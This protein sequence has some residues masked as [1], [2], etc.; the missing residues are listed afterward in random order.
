MIPYIG[1]YLLPAT[2]ALQRIALR[3]VAAWFLGILF[4][5]FI[6]LRFDV[7][8]DWSSYL[9]HLERTAGLGVG[10]VLRRDEPGYYL[11]N[12]LAAHL[13]AGIWLVNLVCG[14]L[15]VAGLIR[16]CRRMPEPFLALA[17]ATPYIVTVVAMGYTRQATAFGLVLW[18]LVYLFDQRRLA[19][20]VSV[21]LAAT[22]HKSAV[23]MLPLAVLAATERRVWTAF[24][25]GISG[26][27]MYLL[28]L[29][30]Q[31]AT[32]W[33]NY[34]ESDYAMASEG[35]P[36]RVLMNVVPAAVLLLFHRRFQMAPGIKALWFWMAVFSFVALPLVFQ[37]ATAV[38]RVALYLMP[39]QLVVWSH[40]PG[41]FRPPQR[42][43]VRLG[44][45]YV[46]GAVLIVWLLFA[47][48]AFAWLPYRFYPLASL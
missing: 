38:D 16:F 26:A 18:G 42:A 29:A 11:L 28:F 19:F 44:V 1:L 5:L 34:V 25:V 13:G 31:T 35:G 7:G 24:W 6:G 22:F 45:L 9:T 27:V 36:I 46:Y 20:A 40:L 17:V 23:L 12:W 30:E 21:A 39:I 14:A 15:F 48:H 3:G 4:A 41:L 43:F 32:L 37:A 8:G 10:E 2:F 47:S 33:N